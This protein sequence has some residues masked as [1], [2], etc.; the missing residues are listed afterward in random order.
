M[1]MYIQ[2][3]L[4]GT[5]SMSGE[6][7]SKAL[8]WVCLLLMGAIAAWPSRALS[9]TMG[10]FL[11]QGG[12]VFNVKAYGATGNGTTNDSASV[13]NAINAAVSAGGGMVYFPAGTYFLDAPKAG[14]TVAITNS[15]PDIISLVGIGMG[16]QLKFNTPVGLTIPRAAGQNLFHGAGIMHAQLVCAHRPARLCR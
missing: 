2:K 9:Q 10:T 16:T 6:W 14:A 7:P 4:A 15:R 11:D 5:G 1:Y 8:A 13:Q 12:A 3:I